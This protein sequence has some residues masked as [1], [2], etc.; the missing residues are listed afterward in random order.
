M[1]TTSRDEPGRHLARLADTGHHVWVLVAALRGN[2]GDVRTTATEWHV[3][4]DQIQAAVGYYKRN[5]DVFDA[6][7]LLQEEI[8][9]AL[10]Q[11]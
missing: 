7:F 8:D 10:D 3:T 2:G 9:R 4:E 6:F 5:R 1:I 11:G